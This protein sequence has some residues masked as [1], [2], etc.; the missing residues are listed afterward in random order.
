M[1]E[2]TSNSKFSNI[3]ISN[4]TKI[5]DFTFNIYENIVYI[6]NTIH[7]DINNNLELNIDNTNITFIIQN[8]FKPEYKKEIT[9]IKYDKEHEFISYNHFLKQNDIIILENITNNSI[10]LLQDNLQIDNILFKVIKTTRNSFILKTA[11]NYNTLL[12]N[13][14]N[15]VKAPAILNNSYFYI[16][17]NKLIKQITQVEKNNKFYCINHGLKLND[18][19]KLEN[20]K[21]NNINLLESYYQKDTLLY[22]VTTIQDNIFE[23]THYINNKISDESN[24]ILIINQDSFV[25]NGYFKLVESKNI[26]STIN[27]NLPNNL[28]DNYGIYYNIIINDNITKLSINTKNNDILIGS[29]NIGSDYLL[30]SEIIETSN[31]YKKFIVNDINLLYTKLEIINIKKNIWYINCNIFDN[32]ISYKVTYN[33]GEIYLNNTLLSVQNF[34]INFIYEFDISDSNLLNNEFSIVN[35]NYSSYFKDILNVGLI[36]KS[37]SKLIIYINKDSL[38]DSEYYIRYKKNIIDDFYL[39]KKLFIIKNKPSYFSN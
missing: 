37:N 18:I 31:N 22:I 35:S 10:S 8:I 39:F 6:N 26:N 19:V 34:Y 32:K 28:T 36:G 24:N 15:I 25:T 3:E 27:I 29:C 23:L 1:L 5:K 38:I 33:N 7:T 16:R 9:E 4:I 2:V 14:S 11:N 13:I 30:S 20:I 12:N 17:S 21:Y